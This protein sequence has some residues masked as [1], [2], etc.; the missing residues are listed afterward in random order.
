MIAG[1]VVETSELPSTWNEFTTVEAIMTNNGQAKGN[2]STSITLPNEKH[3][4]P[5]TGPRESMY[6][7]SALRTDK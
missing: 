4:I 7:I 3:S 2:L 5:I 6:N 1:F